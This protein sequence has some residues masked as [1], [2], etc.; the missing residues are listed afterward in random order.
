[1][2]HNTGSSEVVK[3]K[4]GFGYADDVN[5]SVNTAVEGKVRH[6]GIYGLVSL[7]VYD[8]RKNAL[9][10]QGFRKV[11]SPCAVTAV[12]ASELNTVSINVS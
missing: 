7:V 11:N 5:V 3:I 1:M 12:V 2:Y 6:L 9:V 4:V 8:D 10:L